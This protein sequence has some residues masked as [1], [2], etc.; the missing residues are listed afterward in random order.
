MSF[1]LRYADEKLN[2]NA[3]LTACIQTVA[4]RDPFAEPLSFTYGLRGAE[5]CVTISG[6]RKHRRKH[7]A[8]PGVNLELCRSD[9]ADEI[10]CLVVIFPSYPLT[11]PQI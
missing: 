7:A 4:P 10:L 8:N 11:A 2:F 3:D 9:S 5:Y 6:K 1:V